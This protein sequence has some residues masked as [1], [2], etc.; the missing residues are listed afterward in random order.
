MRVGTD[1]NMRILSK[2]GGRLV[3]L[4]RVPIIARLPIPESYFKDKKERRNLRLI[5]RET[6]WTVEPIPVAKRKAY[7]HQT[8]L[9]K[10][11]KR[12]KTVSRRRKIMKKQNAI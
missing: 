3:P 12:I 1:W 8:S 2:T 9:G 4:S 6:F 7:I 5:V 10:P 11:K